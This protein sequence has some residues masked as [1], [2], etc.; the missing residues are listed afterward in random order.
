MAALRELAAA[1]V[2]GHTPSDFPLVALT[3]DDVDAFAGAAETCCR[4]CRCRRACTS[5]R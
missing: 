4:C 5:T 1:D 2:A 3:Q